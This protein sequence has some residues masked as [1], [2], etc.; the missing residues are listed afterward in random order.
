M[1][2]SCKMSLSFVLLFLFLYGCVR[3]MGK[4]GYTTQTPRERTERVVGFDT[5]KIFE[6]ERLK[7]N[8]T[9]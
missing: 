5:A 8:V 6:A 3:L 7:G 2:N 1:R 9:P 4:A